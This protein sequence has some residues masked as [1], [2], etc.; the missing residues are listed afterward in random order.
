M[1]CSN[2]KRLK[3]QR[4]VTKV[5]S[6]RQRKR[7]SLGDSRNSQCNRNTNHTKSC[8]VPFRV[9]MLRKMQV[10]QTTNRKASMLRL[11]VVIFLQENRGNRSF[12]GGAHRM[13]GTKTTFV[14]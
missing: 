13:H 3:I 4:T 11:S 7:K 5:R 1:C 9:R 10:L 12:F 6:M 8:S 14:L 2:T